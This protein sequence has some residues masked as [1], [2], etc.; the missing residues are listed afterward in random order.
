MKYIFFVWIIIFVLACRK[1]E[2]STYSSSNG[3]A[4]FVGEFEPDS[5]MYS[6]AFAPVE[7]QRDTIYLRMRIQGPAAD[8]SRQINL[9][10]DTGSTAREG[11]DYIFPAFEV[12]AGAITVNYPLIVLNSPEMKTTTFRLVA[13]VEEN[14]DF[15]PGATGEEIGGTIAIARMKI[16][17]T[18]RIATPQYWFDVEGAFGQFSETKFKFMVQVTGLTDFSYEAIGV[19]GYY[20]LPVK[21]RNALSEY[22]A[23]NGP[24]LDENGNPVTF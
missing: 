8:H 20:N 12:P 15:V 22:E 5:L 13:R 4:F 21:L 7:L 6:F 3:I 1:S 9:T 14:K 11:V 16:D 17:I 18:N 19:D 2:I 24:L 10:A 23:E